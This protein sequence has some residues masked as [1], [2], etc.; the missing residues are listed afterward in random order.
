MER[1]G[2][3]SLQDNGGCS[4]W[5]K[6]NEK[7]DKLREYPEGMVSLVAQLQVVTWL[8]MSF[9]VSLLT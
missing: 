2:K 3:K 5:R 9:C 6:G 4:E 8:G 7:H 1:N